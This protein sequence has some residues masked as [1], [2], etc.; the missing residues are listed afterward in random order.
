MSLVYYTLKTNIHVGIRSDLIDFESNI[1]AQHLPPSFS[2]PPF[3]KTDHDPHHHSLHPHWGRC[4][5]NLYDC[6][7]CF[8]IYNLLLD[9]QNHVPRLWPHFHHIQNSYGFQT[10]SLNI[11]AL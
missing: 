1:S 7:N 6:Y 2:L 4:F 8:K 9:F 11:L 3:H 5:Q 10:Q